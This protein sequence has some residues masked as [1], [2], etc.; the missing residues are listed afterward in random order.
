MSY[1][2]YLCSKVNKIYLDNMICLKR[3]FRIHLISNDIGKT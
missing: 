2:K 1:V 3:H